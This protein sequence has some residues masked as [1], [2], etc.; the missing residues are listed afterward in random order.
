MPNNR[1]LAEARCAGVPCIA[2]VAGRDNFR[3]QST[4][5]DFELRILKPAQGFSVKAE[6][7]QRA[8]TV[9]ALSFHVSLSY[10]PKAGLATLDRSRANSSTKE[11]AV[12]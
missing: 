10:R 8:G 1:R 4:Q 2:A 9:E 3:T 6:G 5:G 7:F 11:S 12:A